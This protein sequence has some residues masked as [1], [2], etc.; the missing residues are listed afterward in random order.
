MCVHSVRLSALHVY[1]GF[2]CWLYVSVVCVGL[3]GQL[4]VVVFCVGFLCW[5]YVLDFC[6]GFMCW[7]DLLVSCVGFM[8]WFSSALASRDVFLSWSDSFSGPWKLFHLAFFLPW[9]TA[10]DLELG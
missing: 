6:A 9:Q 4:F 3:L 10:D 1:V 8:C 7:F 2:L 5:L